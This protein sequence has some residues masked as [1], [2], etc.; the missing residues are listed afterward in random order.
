MAGNISAVNLYQTLLWKVRNFPDNVYAFRP[1]DNLTT[2]MSVLLDGPGVGQLS[3]VQTAARINQ[4]YLEF[5]DIDRVLGI[6]TGLSRASTEIYSLNTNPFIDQLTT[7]GWLDVY[8]KDSTF[9]GRMDSAMSARTKGATP[10]GVRALAESTLGTRVS[11]TEG[12]NIPTD[13]VSSNYTVSVSGNT[14]TTLA[15]GTVIV[16]G[17]ITTV[18]GFIPTVVNGV[19]TSGYVGYTTAAVTRNFG[20]NELVFTPYLLPDVPVDNNILKSLAATLQTLIPAESIV[21]VNKPSAVNPYEQIPAIVISGNS[22][23]F[24]FDRQVLA[25]N[26]N[27]PANINSTQGTTVVANGRY[28]LQ[29]NQTVPA[30][31]F[32]HLQTQEDI[33]NVTQNIS[34]VSVTPISTAGNPAPYSTSSMLGVG[35][36]NITSTVYGAV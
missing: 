32:A 10:F 9:K 21:T 14:I 25:N 1:E 19:V 24:F 35:T 11:F 2:L 17:T 7:S 27:I 23:F 4:L 30:A 36:L 3:S 16:S 33:I 20:H 26:I 29:N 12:F 8:S 15:S 5:S 13:T 31:Y 22:Q 6:L 28:W 34:T 18:S